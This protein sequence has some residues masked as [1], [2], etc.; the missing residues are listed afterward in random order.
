MG[1]DTGGRRILR[2]VCSWSIVLLGLGCGAKEEDVRDAPVD[3]AAGGRP[4]GGAANAGD[5]S[6]GAGGD[7]GP[8]PLPRGGGTNGGAALGWEPWGP[9]PTYGHARDQTRRKV[10]ADAHLPERPSLAWALTL[11]V[12]RHT[13]FYSSAVIGSDDVLYVPFFGLWDYYPS[14]GIQAIGAAGEPRWFFA[15][16]E[17]EAQSPL[18]ARD[19]ATGDTVIVF[20]SAGRPY[21]NVLL[22]DPTRHFP[23]MMAIY[24]KPAC[25]CCVNRDE[26]ASFCE[27]SCVSA[28]LC[29]PYDAESP[30][31]WRHTAHVDPESGQATCEHVDP[32]CA[33]WLLSTDGLDPSRV[34]ASAAVGYYE[35]STTPLLSADGATVYYSVCGVDLVADLTNMIVAVDVASRTVRWFLTEDDPD[36]WDTGECSSGHN[37]LGWVMSSARFSDGSLLY[38]TRAGCLVRIVDHGDRGATEG[39]YRG[40]HPSVVGLT[41]EP[42]PTDDLVYVATHGQVP[43]QPGDLYQ[44]SRSRLLATGADHEPLWTFPVGEAL[45]PDDWRSDGPGLY[46]SPM[47]YEED[48]AKSVYV[49]AGDW[50][51]EGEVSWLDPDRGWIVRVPGDGPD[52]SERWLPLELEGQWFPAFNCTMDGGGNVWLHGGRNVA[53]AESGRVLRTDRDLTELVA[54]PAGTT[55]RFGFSEVV[56]GDSY[57]YAVSA[58]SWDGDD[59]V[60]PVVYRFE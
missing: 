60:A 11:P 10:R 25:R 42:A 40:A 56:L 59:V 44:T 53:V 38:G 47:L 48:G 30:Y 32:A 8:G 57:L 46:G 21:G 52:G 31:E 41:I 7:A 54:L 4:G 14:G 22:P 5:A 33:A 18:V 2:A 58:P 49:V 20:G 43:Q 15:S 13:M 51:D 39:L 23:A 35:V 6:G 50:P 9:W 26:A 28:E 34:P 17:T 27:F 45:A 3:G 1:T 37:Q 19:R 24:D 36:G 16:R 29:A 12:A 55:T